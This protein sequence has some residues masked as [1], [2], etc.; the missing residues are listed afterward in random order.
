MALDVTGS[1]FGPTREKEIELE[2]TKKR[3]EHALADENTRAKV[4][5]DYKYTFEQLGLSPEQSSQLYSAVFQSLT[6]GKGLLEIEAEILRTLEATKLQTDGKE[7][8]LIEILHE[9][10]KDRAKI[11]AGQVA[12]YLKG[13]LGKVIDYGAGDGQV[14]QNLQDQLS[15]NGE[16]FDIEGVDVRGYKAPNVTVPVKVF[17]GSHVEVPDQTYEA[18]LLTNVL[19][20]EKDNENILTELDR[21]TKKR[22]VIL[23]TVPM[24]GSEEAMQN[25]KDRTFMNDYLYNRMFHSADVPVPGTFETP[26]GWKDRLEGQHNWKLVHE[27]D[28]GVDQPT[29]KDRH[30]L[31]VFEK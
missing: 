20:H 26:K 18:A 30:Y 2:M 21:I 11:I 9:K 8:N 17:D 29:I 4:E 5:A 1:D 23:E 25:D 12:P 27:E 28:L 13:I 7:Q 22:L 19:H 6:S 3:I 14:T 24:G 31:L 10:L 15:I 16:E